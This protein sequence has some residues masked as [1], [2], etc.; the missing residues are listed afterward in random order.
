MVLSRAPQVTGEQA[1]ASQV[2]QSQPSC[3][4]PDRQSA[5]QLSVFTKNGEKCEI[6]VVRCYG[7]RSRSASSRRDTYW[8]VG[9][10]RASPLAF[11]LI[12]SRPR[13]FYPS[14]HR[15]SSTWCWLW[16]R[17]DGVALVCPDQYVTPAT[18]IGQCTQKN[19]G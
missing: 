2:C 15:P 4:Q 6:R 19:K 17:R 16:P 10:A 1:T 5:P 8:Q 13:R 18:K 14:L 9:S 7:T 11:N 3:F 12:A